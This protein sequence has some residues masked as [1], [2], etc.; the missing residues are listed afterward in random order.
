M[1]AARFR[2]VGS[3]KSGSALR[4]HVLGGRKTAS[5]IPQGRWATKTAELDGAAAAAAYG[6]F[7]NADDLW[8]DSGAF[9]L[10]TLEAR[11]MDPQQ[12]FVLHV[13]YAAL[14]ARESDWADRETRRAD[15]LCCD[16]GV[17]VGVEPSGLVIAGSSTAFS[18]TGA[19]ASITSGRLSFALGLV[20]PCYT[21][22]TACSSALA[23]LHVSK[24]AVISEGECGRAVAVG[25]KAL[26][27][28]ANYGTAVAGMTSVHGR[29]HTFDGRAD[30]Y[31]RG[32]GCVAFC[33]RQRSAPRARNED[34]V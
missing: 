9:G 18:A 1:V 21:I 16:V 27:E 8:I 30:G 28:A 19:A 20:G 14:V 15:L 34:D 33:V 25:T 24:A 31:C 2:I 4:S 6:S 5:G 11:S 17:F 26:S 10:F 3:T 13:G 7:L 32:E 22:D 23:A 12:V 29:C